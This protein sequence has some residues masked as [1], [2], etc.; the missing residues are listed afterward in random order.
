[1]NRAET[2]LLGI[3]GIWGFT[4]PAMKV[5]LDYIP[6]ILFLAYR[7]GIASLF[8]LLIFRRRAL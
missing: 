6:P 1:M 8:M 5:S 2:I 3:T 4:F 7:F